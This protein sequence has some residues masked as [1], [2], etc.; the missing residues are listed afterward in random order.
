MRKDTF[1]IKVIQDNKESVKENN[2]ATFLKLME[3]IKDQFVDNNEYAKK[4]VKI[5]P[6]VEEIEINIDRNRDCDIPFVTC[7]ID[8]ESY[9]VRIP[10][11]HRIMW[12]ILL[13]SSK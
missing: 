12:G 13:E 8:G 4:F 10:R 1:E 3:G 5:I 11:F 2:R 7:I 6:E 9:V